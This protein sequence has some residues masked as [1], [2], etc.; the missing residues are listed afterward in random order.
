MVYNPILSVFIPYYIIYQCYIFTFPIICIQLLSYILSI[1]IYIISN[2]IISS[3]LYQDY[4]C[5]HSNICTH[6]ITNNDYNITIHYIIITLSIYY[7]YQLTLYI[8]SIMVS[9]LLSLLI[10]IYSYIVPITYNHILIY[11]LSHYIY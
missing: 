6:C 11:I 10:Y 4:N 3:L 5:I 2:Y 7:S 8:I 9:I 1:H